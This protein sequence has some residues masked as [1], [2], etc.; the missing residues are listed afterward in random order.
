MPKTD[1]DR[2]LFKDWFDAQ[3]A[4]KLGKQVAAAAQAVGPNNTRS[5]KKSLSAWPPK[6]WT[7]WK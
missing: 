3:A 5:T 4:Q 6:G 7:S 1:N 2:P